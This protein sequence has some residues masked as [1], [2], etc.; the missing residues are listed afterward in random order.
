MRELQCTIGF[1]GKCNGFLRNE[2]VRFDSL[3]V[4][5]KKKSFVRY[6]V[7]KHADRYKK[8]HVFLNFSSCAFVPA[9]LIFVL[10]FIFIW[11][12]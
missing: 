9:G 12:T 5:E 7:L 11:E 8:T 1:I 10:K 4:F 6:P 3:C 2:S